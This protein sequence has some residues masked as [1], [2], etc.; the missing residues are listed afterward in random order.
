MH[1]D[2]SVSFDWFDD[3]PLPQLFNSLE[4][5]FKHPEFF[6]KSFNRD[7]VPVQSDFVWEF[8]VESTLNGQSL[9]SWSKPVHE[10]KEL[11]LF[12]VSL[13]KPVNMLMVNRYSFN[14]KESNKFRIYYGENL[15]SKIKPDYIFLGKAYPNPTGGVTS[16]PFSLPE[17][18]SSYQVKVEVYDMMGKK[19][20]TVAE[21]EF[22]PGFYTS[23]W[24][25]SVSNAGEGL[26]IYQMVVSDQ[27]RNELKSGKVVLRK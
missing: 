10:D 24:N 6:A 3:L 13:Q 2:A 12:D 21:G 18:N 14:P 26:Y 25:S 22:K 16:I 5:N 23:E 17:T 27:N 11:Y 7:I 9:M 4:M 8:S 19:V 1:P 20:A 15:E